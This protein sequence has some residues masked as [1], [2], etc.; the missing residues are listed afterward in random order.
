MVIS[1][2]LTI[3]YCSLNTLSNKHI[4]INMILLNLIL[5]ILGIYLTI[6]SIINGKREKLTGKKVPVMCL[7]SW[8][9]LHV[10]EDTYNSK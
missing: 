3:M 2:C 7:R 1:G 5:I 8:N 10:I 6:I 4:G 9:I